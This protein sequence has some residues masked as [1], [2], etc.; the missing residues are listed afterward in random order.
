MQ[1]YFFTLFPFLF[2]TS[3]PVPAQTVIFTTARYPVENPEPGVVI[4][5]LED[6]HSLEQSL[7]PALSQHP[8][9]AE[10]RAREQM[11]Q[12]DWRE[13]EARLTRAYQSL[14]DAYA[15]GVEKVPAVVLDERY[16]VYGTT[17]IRVAEKKRD[18]WQETQ[19]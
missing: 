3:V 17:D 13:Q 10:Q 2:L 6:I 11:K 8:E 5:V 18:T 4:Q 9:Q 15:L 7:F 16:V 14:L 19:P 12:P 1:H